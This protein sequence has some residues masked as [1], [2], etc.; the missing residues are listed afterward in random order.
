MNGTDTAA[1]RL[2]K[3]TTDN[4]ELFIQEEQSK[5]SEVAHT[6]EVIGYLILEGI[7]VQPVELNSITFS[8]AF[9]SEQE[10]TISGF[11]VYN[12]SNLLCEVLDPTARD[13]SC[14]TK[15]DQTNIFTLTTI[16]LSGEESSPSNF[17]QFIK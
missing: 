17:L 16:N 15:L 13:I 3:V 12:N 5:D 6:K 2:E 10:S 9:D 1:L 11:R 14:E 4:V 8:W 7:V